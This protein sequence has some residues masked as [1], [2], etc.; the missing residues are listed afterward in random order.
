MRHVLVDYA[1]KVSTQKRGGRCPIPLDEAVVIAP[2]RL[3]EVIALDD[4]LKDLGKASARG[5]AKWW[6]SATLAA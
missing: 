2:G 3:K 4:A 1:R 5:N 6:N